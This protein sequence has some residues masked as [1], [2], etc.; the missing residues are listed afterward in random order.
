M[1][2][3]TFDAELIHT[4]S[5][6]RRTTSGTPDEW[7]AVPESITPVVT[8]VPC[9]IQTMEETIEFTKRGKKLETRLCGFFQY[10]L[11]I[12]EDDIVTFD[13]KQYLVIAVE[14]AAGQAH[15]LEVYLWNLQN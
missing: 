10:G 1:S 11:N 7:G 2:D 8:G 15:H 9:L 4:V 3:P 14:D 5:I 12:L 13:G 6:S